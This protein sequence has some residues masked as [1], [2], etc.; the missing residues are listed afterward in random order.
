MSIISFI[1][2]SDSEIKKKGTENKFL[3]F[4]MIVVIAIYDDF[5]ARMSFVPDLVSVIFD[6]HYGFFFPISLSKNV[7]IYFRVTALYSAR[8]PLIC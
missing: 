8:V 3:S 4:L 7:S 1:R 2:I 6:S 5:D